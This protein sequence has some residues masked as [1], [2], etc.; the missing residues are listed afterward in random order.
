MRYDINPV[1]TLDLDYRYLATT[2]STFG[3]PNTTLHY[4]TG[5]NTNNFMASLT[6]RFGSLP[7]DLPSTPEPPLPQQAANVV[8][9]LVSAGEAG[10]G[11]NRRPPPTSDRV[12]TQQVATGVCLPVNPCVDR[13]TYL[14]F[15]P[16]LVVTDTAQ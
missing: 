11:S 8:D 1:L 4:R 13:L 5:T 16:H 2:E 12:S 6:Y 9:A 15:G 10:P 14:S 7:T 3:I